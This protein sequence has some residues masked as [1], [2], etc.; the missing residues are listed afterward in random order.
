MSPTLVAFVPARAGSERVQ[1]KNVR[2]LEGHP[3]IAYA[4]AAAR[5]SGVADRVVCSTD[6]EEI[7]E[8][9]RWYGADVPFLRPSEYAGS[10]SPDI[11]WLS[12]T[13]DRLPERYELFAIVRPTSP[14]RGPDALRRA[15]DRL[16]E[17]PEA[18]SIRAVELARQH[19][20]KMWLLE[21]QTM[22]PFL[23]Q[24]DLAVPW[25]DSQYQSL[26]KVYVQTS[27]LE[28]AWSRVVAEGSL[29]GHVRVPFFAE[30][31]EGFS[32]DYEEDWRRAEE[33]AAAGAV[34]PRIDVDPWQP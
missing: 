21:G 15:R 34:L 4:I 8:I 31:H 27:A 5:Q 22:R 25:H 32:I 12:D 6:S 11:E 13:L 18:S 30:G 23:D 2:R 24:S 10:A 20:G 29:G 16:L 3:L 17:V 26:P 1:G 14:F 7:A 9:A 33:L 28:I 19:P